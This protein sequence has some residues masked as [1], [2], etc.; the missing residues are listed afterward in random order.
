LVLELLSVGLIGSDGQY[1]ELEGRWSQLMTFISRTKLAESLKDRADARLPSTIR[2]WPGQNTREI[3]PGAFL[4][5]VVAGAAFAIRQLPGMATFSPMILSMVIGIAFHNIVG[6]AAWAKQGV[7][8]SLRWL[9]RIAISS[10]GLQ[11]TSSQVI[12]IGGG[13]LGII[14]AIVR[15]CFAFTIW[16]GE[17]LGVEPT[18]APLIAAATSICGASAVIATN[19]VTNAH[20]EEVAYAIACVTVFGSVAMFAHPIPAHAKVWIVAATTFLSIALAA[21]GLETDIGQLTAK[22]F[23][24]A[25]LG[26]LAFLLIAGFSLTLIKLME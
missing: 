11:L 5:S 1:L 3:L 16:I 12:G 2:R 24:P 14:A 7:T 18:L 19:T 21:T 4:N 13:G 15:A 8:F 22:D 6:A 17:L 20:D 23:R 9:P 10:L 26:A 25:L